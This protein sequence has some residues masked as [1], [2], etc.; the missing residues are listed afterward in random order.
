M[1][2]YNEQEILGEFF[3]EVPLFTISLLVHATAVEAM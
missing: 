2:W 3:V 1:A